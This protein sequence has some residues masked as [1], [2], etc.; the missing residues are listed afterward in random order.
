MATFDSTK[1]YIQ[2]NIRDN[3]IG[4]I[5]GDLLQL[6]LL[7]IVETTEQALTTINTRLDKIEDTLRDIVVDYTSENNNTPDVNTP[8]TPPTATVTP[9]WPE[10]RV[11][12]N[13][14]RINNAICIECG[15]CYDTTI[16]CK[17]NNIVVLDGHTRPTVIA[18]NYLTSAGVPG[19]LYT[20]CNNECIS[21]CTYNAITLHNIQV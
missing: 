10:D 5:T 3:G 20:T 14:A 16:G 8:G 9:D 19:C 18:D 21:A 1:Q 4:N 12:N 2:A 6:V 7:N 11:K 17:Y 15:K 13:F